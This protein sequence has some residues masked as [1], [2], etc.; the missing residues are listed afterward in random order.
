MSYILDALRKADSE[1]ERGEVPNIHSQPVPL[2]AAEAAEPQPVHPLVWAVAGLLVV[3]LALLAWLLWGRDAGGDGKA[4]PVEAA[5]GAAVPLTAKPPA[6][7]PA[8]YA[9]APVQSAQAPVQTPAQ[10]VMPSQPAMQG[11]PAPS[12]LPAPVPPAAAT[13]GAMARP[14]Q[15]TAARQTD[16]QAPTA[17]APAMSATKPDAAAQLGSAESRIYARDELPADVRR[18]LPQLAIGG[19]MYSDEPSGRML[20]INGHVFHEG[21]HVSADLTIERIELKSAVLKFKG[22]RYSVGY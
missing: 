5:A 18:E 4:A 22:Y 17:A 1:R 15:P 14:A 20:I 3:V 2:A 16:A 21:D 6:D 12:H 9:P 7:P 8:A 13:V 10:A 19:S 11:A